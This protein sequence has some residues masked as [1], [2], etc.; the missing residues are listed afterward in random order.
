[1][2]ISRHMM[3]ATT[4]AAYTLASPVFADPKFTATNVP[5]ASQTQSRD[6]QQGDDKKPPMSDCTKP[7]TDPRCRP[8]NHHYYPY[9]DHPRPVIVNQLPPQPAIDINSLTDDWEGCRKAKLGAIRARNSGH[10]D[11]AN[12]LDD[13]LWKNCRSY[14]NELRQLEQDDM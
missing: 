12:T 6:S 9:P 5:P 3:I 10:T 14:S 4:V 13:W 1:M 11:E 7:S 2:R 8:A